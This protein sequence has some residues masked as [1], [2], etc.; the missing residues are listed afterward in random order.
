MHWQMQAVRPLIHPKLTADERRYW[1]WWHDPQKVLDECSAI[2][3]H[4]LVSL[5]VH[6]VEKM[7]ADFSSP[8]IDKT[9]AKAWN[10]FLKTV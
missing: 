1:G 7:E 8:D 10:A 6:T 3:L 2:T 5:V 9:E 4:R